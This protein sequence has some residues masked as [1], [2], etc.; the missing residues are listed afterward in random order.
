MIVAPGFAREDWIVFGLRCE[1]QQQANKLSATQCY[2]VIYR[3]NNGHV[4]RSFLPQW[5]HMV[6]WGSPWPVIG[7]LQAKWLLPKGLQ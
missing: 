1:L 5:K 4:T 2:L 6:I 3:G 7:T